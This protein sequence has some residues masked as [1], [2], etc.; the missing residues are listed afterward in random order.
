MLIVMP[1]DRKAAASAKRVEPIL[2]PSATAPVI[3]QAIKI[4]I[5]DDHKMLRQG[6]RRVLEEQDGFTV[7]GEAGDGAEA[8]ALARV[9]EPQVVIMDVNMPNMNGIEA[10]EIN[11]P[12][13]AVGDRY[14][15]ILRHRGFCG[16]GDAGGWSGDLPA[17]RT[18][19]RRC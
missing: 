10:T 15:P 1:M 18:C 2:L 16:P 17:Q 5:V 13:P 14:R 11:H 7:V 12:G 4:L 9:L 19:R 3:E 8:V 6:L